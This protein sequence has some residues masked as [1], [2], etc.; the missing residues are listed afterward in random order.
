MDIDS[1]INQRIEADTEFQETL[2][3]LSDEERAEALTIKRQE[4]LSSEFASLSAKAQEAEKAKELAENYKIRAEKAEKEKGS[5]KQATDTLTPKD[6]LA[7]TEQKVTSEDF[8]EIV[9]VAG[10]L[11]KPVA[12]ALNDNVLKTILKTRQEER[13][14]ALA[15]NTGG[16]NRGSKGVTPDVLLRKAETGEVGEEDIER[17]AQARMAQRTGQK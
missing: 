2:T 6:F 16:G 3:T 5:A 14:T 10:L 9:R 4:V 8:D 17:L 13:A 12:E 1:L 7:L 15:T 11:G